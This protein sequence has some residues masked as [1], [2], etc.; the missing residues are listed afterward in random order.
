MKI[1]GAEKS[2]K[3]CRDGYVIFTFSVS[4]I[5]GGLISGLGELLQEFLEILV[6]L[7]QEGVIQIEHLIPQQQLIGQPFL[8]LLEQALLLLFGLLP[9]LFFLLEI[10]PQS[11]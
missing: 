11:L 9:S 3:E 6:S 10:L 2:K 4:A 7:V 1:Y 8:D 5:L